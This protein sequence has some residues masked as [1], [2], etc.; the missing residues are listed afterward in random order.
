VAALRFLALSGWRESEALSLRWDALD[1][2]RSV[3]ILQDTKTGRSVRPLGS[4]A[5]DVI[6][7]LSDLTGSPFVFPGGKLGEHL[8]DGNRIWLAAKHEAGLQ[9]RLH[10]LRHSFTTVARE[11]GYS[12]EV[13]ARLVGHTLEGMTARYGDVPDEIVQQAAHRVS[14]T[15]A[16]RMSGRSTTTLPFRPQSKDAVA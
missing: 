13:I 9:L 10:D 8:K 1:L 16:N 3:A 2:D 5:I 15:I 7:S 6:R 14:D 12:N 11:L 4:A